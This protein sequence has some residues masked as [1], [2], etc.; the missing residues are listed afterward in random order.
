MS[1][2]MALTGDPGETYNT[3]DTLRHLEQ[4]QPEL[5]WVLGDLT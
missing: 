4:S 5:V 3:T 2:N 1:F